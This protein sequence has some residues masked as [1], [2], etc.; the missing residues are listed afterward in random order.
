MG[1]VA[2]LVSSPAAAR[3]IRVPGEVATIQEAID[4]AAPFDTILVAP[5]DYDNV[6][7]VISYNQRGIVLTSEKGSH[8]TILNALSG[9]RLITFDEADTMTELSG[10]TLQGGN[11]NFDGGAVYAYRSQILISNCEFI[12]NQTQGD[13][14]AVALYETWAFLWRNVITANGARQGGGVYSSTS[15]L[16]LSGNTF[17]N[18]RARQDGGGLLVL[19]SA[20]TVDGNSFEGNVAERE[21]GGV[22]FFSAQGEFRHNRFR[23]NSARQGGGFV[24]SGGYQPD[25][26]TNTFTENDPSDLS[27]CASG[28]SQN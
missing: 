4:G 20:P 1:L 15:T 18:N 25:L 14:G 11:P 12:S 16:T 10:F 5:G 23:R 26:S 8:E 6:A 17:R 9:S 22:A 28:A 21:G 19:N 2:L 3:V 7:L 24:C 27:G 13:G